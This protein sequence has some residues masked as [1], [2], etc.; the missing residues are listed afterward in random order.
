MRGIIAVMNSS[1]ESESLWKMSL[2]IFTSAWLCPT[3]V[4][5]TLQFSMALQMKFMLLSDIFYN[6][7]HSIIPNYL[8]ISYDI[9]LSLHVMSKFSV[10]FKLFW[11][12]V[13]LNIVGH[14]FFFSC[15]ILLVLPKIN[16]GIHSFFICAVKIFHI[17]SKKKFRYIVAGCRSFLFC[18]GLL[19]QI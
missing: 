17:L 16:P 8:I 4:N 14:L 7:R 19:F 13:A 15:D 3:A 1:C 10:S 18:W 6:F 11:W 5:S 12:C 9:L 2:L